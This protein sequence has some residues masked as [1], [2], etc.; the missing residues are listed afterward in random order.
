MTLTLPGD[1]NGKVERFQVEDVEEGCRWRT[2]LEIVICSCID[3]CIVRDVFV[4]NGS[5]QN[6]CF[7]RSSWL[8][9]EHNEER[10][11]LGYMLIDLAK[12][13]GRVKAA[14]R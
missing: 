14:G 3:L 2:T 6:S 10:E 7:H 4:F 12:L 9:G 5:F 13:S 8:R 11:S 1:M